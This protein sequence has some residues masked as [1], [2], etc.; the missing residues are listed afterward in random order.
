ML[1]SC[2]YKEYFYHY[3]NLSALNLKVFYLLYSST[4]FLYIIHADS[5]QAIRMRLDRF[6]LNK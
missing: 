1:V 2:N 4:D 5:S 3:D 6:I